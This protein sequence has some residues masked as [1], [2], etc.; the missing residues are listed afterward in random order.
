MTT[1]TDPTYNNQFDQYFNEDG[2]E[3]MDI[4]ADED[5]E[6]HARC[7]RYWQEQYEVVSNR[8][9]EEVARLIGR[10]EKALN[11]IR[12]R[13]AWHE[14]S[15]K[16]FYQYKG[17]K[18]LVMANATLSSQKGRERIEVAD[19]DALESWA[20]TEGYESLL[21][22]KVDPDKAAIMAHVKNT[23]EEPPGVSLERGEDSFKV[24]F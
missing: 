18:R 1:I 9:D 16:M 24:K 13:E 15:L 7:L 14:A 19:M 10:A 2:P 11:S 6:V 5:A 20:V 4:R 17:E 8:F 21:N 23:G 3:P 22:R 12:R